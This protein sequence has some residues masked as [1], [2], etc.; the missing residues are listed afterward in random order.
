MVRRID[1]L[2]VVYETRKY[3]THLVLWYQEAHALSEHVM[4]SNERTKALKGFELAYGKTESLLLVLPKVP[5]LQSN[6]YEAKSPH[7]IESLLP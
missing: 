5:Y 6:E 2:A 4:N 1:A 3:I 7:L